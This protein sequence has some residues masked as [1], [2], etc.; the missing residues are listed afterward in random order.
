MVVFRS[1][2]QK[3]LDRPDIVSLFE[4]MGGEGMPKGMT[5]HGFP[6]ADVAHGLSHRPLDGL[7]LQVMPT[8]D[9]G[10]GILAPAIGRKEPCQ[11]HSEA[12]PGYFRSRA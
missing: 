3:L 12:A 6:D 9:T 11:P 7:I 4:Q 8:L 1:L 2:S 5:A 10:A